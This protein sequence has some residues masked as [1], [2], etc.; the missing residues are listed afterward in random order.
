MLD[1]DNLLVSTPKSTKPWPHK[2]PELVSQERWNPYIPEV[3]KKIF[4]VYKNDPYNFNSKH[5]KRL[6]EHS[7]NEDVKNSNHQRGIFLLVFSFLSVNIKERNT[8]KP[9]KLTKVA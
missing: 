6:S 1:F 3:I 8:E 2:C 4:K 7:T 9:W 5:N